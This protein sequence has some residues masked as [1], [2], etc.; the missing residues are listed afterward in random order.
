MCGRP[1]C[2]I[3]AG[4]Q[5]GASKLAKL[6]VPVARSTRLPR[7]DSF[8]GYAAENAGDRIT[9]IADSVTAGAPCAATP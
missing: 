7:N 4:S 9:K 1:P 2:S 5:Y 3:A 6:R 8:H